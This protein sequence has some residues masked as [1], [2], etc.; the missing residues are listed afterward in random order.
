MRCNTN[1]PQLTHY[2]CAE[3]GKWGP[4]PPPRFYLCA[5][6][7]A[8]PMKECADN[9]RIPVTPR[10]IR[11]WACR[12]GRKQCC[13]HPLPRERLASNFSEPLLAVRLYFDTANWR[14]DLRFTLRGTPAVTSKSTDDFSDSAPIELGWAKPFEIDPFLPSPYLKDSW[15]CSTRSISQK[16]K[17]WRLAKESMKSIDIKRAKA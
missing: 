2:M 1:S 16:K 4:W 6:L 9:R 8:L 15:N 10:I 13:L 11:L 7:L 5:C 17:Q 3:R 14:E 12:G